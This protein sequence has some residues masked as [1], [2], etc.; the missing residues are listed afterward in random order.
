MMLAFMSD[1][2]GILPANCP[3]YTGV[4]LGIYARPENLG[5]FATVGTAESI[6]GVDPNLAGVYLAFHADNPNPPE[7]VRQFEAMGFGPYRPSG[8]LSVNGASIALHR[9]ADWL[10]SIAG[11]YKFRRGL[12]PNY[13]GSLFN[14]YSRSGSVFVVSQGNPASP[15]DSGYSLEGWDAR[16]YPGT[17][18]YLGESPQSLLCRSRGYSENVLAGGTSMD[19]DGIWGMQSLGQ[20]DPRFVKAG[21]ITFHKS[22]FCFGNRVTLLTTGVGRCE[23]A[24]SEERSLELATTLWQ[25]AFG[26]GGRVGDQNL[27]LGFNTPPKPPPTP[28]AQEPCWVNGE[29][30][31]AFPWA[32]SLPSGPA[33]W[34]IDNKKT[35]YYV[36]PDSPPIRLA[37]RHQTWTFPSSYLLK[38]VPVNKDPHD[39]RNFVPTEGDF[40]AAW[41]E[42]GV[43]PV[44]KECIYT[45]IPA[46]TPDAMAQFAA[47]MDQPDPPYRIVQKNAQAHVVRD[48]ESRT[49]GYVVFDSSW[50]SRATILRAVNRPC[51]VMVTEGQRGLRVSVASTDMD[52]WLR[53]IILSGDIVLTLSGRW[54]LSGNDVGATYDRDETIVRMPYRNFMPVILDLYP[55]S[56]RQAEAPDGEGG[57]QTVVDAEGNIVHP[58]R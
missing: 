16:H 17:T 52:S 56:S 22:A 3:G 54:T 20:T 13:T 19:G 11:K 50:R 39:L 29:K 35:G 5:L 37:R 55:A 43:E 15:W 49:T 58:A 57:T 26:S 4:P 44:W 38:A 9:R 18:A 6:Q 2:R 33:C 21:N 41:F 36:H 28:P 51:T 14:H 47:S 48:R 7:L 8:H 30:I 27:R 31:E 1:A 34:L 42:H 12:E 25:N 23:L 10:V 32:A 46:T 24:T 45:L 53:E 40:S